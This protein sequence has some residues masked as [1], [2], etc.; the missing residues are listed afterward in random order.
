MSIYQGEVHVT[1]FGYTQRGEK[2]RRCE[3]SFRSLF[4]G[5]TTYLLGLSGSQPLDSYRVETQNR[6]RVNQT[7]SLTVTF[8]ST[9]V[10]VGF[11]NDPR[12]V[13]TL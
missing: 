4:T 8:T 2:T 10:T 3:A 6:L 9:T 12:P 13:W 5:Q 7:L 1:T 11:H